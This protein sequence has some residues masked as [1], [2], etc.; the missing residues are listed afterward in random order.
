M[1]FLEIHDHFY[2]RVRKFILASVRDE[3]A[4]DDLVQETFMR[5]HENLDSVRDPGKVS[6]WV[7]RIAHNLCLDHFRARKKSSSHNEIREG[8]VDLQ[9]T[10]PQKRMEQDEMSRCVQGQLNLLPESLRSVLIFSDIMEFSHQEI[11]DILGLSVENVKVRLHRARKRFN[12]IL[13][14]KCTFELDERN[15]LVCE[16]VD[17]K[18]R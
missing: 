11:G 5:I 1:D 16:P 8:L 15:V 2:E 10:P 6:S 13:E 17:K 14:K 9:E 4:V 12:A 7:F 18:R 3:S